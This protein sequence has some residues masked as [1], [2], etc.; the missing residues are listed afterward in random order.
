MEFLGFLA[1]LFGLSLELPLGAVFPVLLDSRTS[2]SFGSGAGTTGVSV[3]VLG[4]RFFLVF[5]LVLF[6]GEALHAMRFLDTLFFLPF[7]P[8]FLLR[9]PLVV[10]FSFNCSSR[11]TNST[12]PV[13]GSLPPAVPC[14]S[15]SAAGTWAKLGSWGSGFLSKTVQ[16]FTGFKSGLRVAMT[17]YFQPAKNNALILFSI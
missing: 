10:A 9:V 3:L 13:S 14:A 16:Q 8:P 2:I 12:F 15:H 6:F 1:I 5:F 17:V 4:M 7:F 11:V